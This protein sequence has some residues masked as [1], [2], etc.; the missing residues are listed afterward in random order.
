MLVG[1]AWKRAPAGSRGSSARPK[2]GRSASRAGSSPPRHRLSTLSHAIDAR[3]ARSE[4]RSLALLGG[5]SAVRALCG[6][7]FVWALESPALCRWPEG[8][9]GRRRSHRI[10]SLVFDDLARDFA[11]ASGGAGAALFSMKHDCPRGLYC[12]PAAGRKKPVVD[13]V[14]VPTLLYVYAQ[15]GAVRGSGVN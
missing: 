13:N 4:S 6:A 8:G 10:A 3:R 2:R 15:E 14:C 12:L 7:D 1:R 11:R 5:V 9:G